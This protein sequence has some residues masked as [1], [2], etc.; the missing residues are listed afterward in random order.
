[1]SVRSHARCP[2][3]VAIG[4]C[5][6]FVQT[7]SAQDNKKEIIEP[8]YRL[9]RKIDVSSG[10]ATTADSAANEA[11]HANEHATTIPA[12]LSTASANNPHPLDRALEMAE[13]GLT[14]IRENIR[15][16]KAIMVKRERVNGE[17]LEP[18]FMEVKIRNA[19]QVGSSQVPF[20]IYMNF[21]KPQS[22][23]GRE[24]IWVQGKN[25]NKI[26]AHETGIK[27]LVGTVR[28]DPNGSLAMT[29]N[30]Y[31]IYEAGIE[32]LVSKL[33]E[34]GTRDRAAGPCEVKYVEDVKLNKRSCTMIEVIH[35]EKKAPYEFHKA[36]IFI[37]DELQVPV[38]Y[39]SYLWPTTPGEK[40]PLLE[41]YTYVNMELNIGLTDR[42]FDHTNP[43]Y[44][45]K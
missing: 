38:R 44:N 7:G 9:S 11:G 3:A 29:G 4:C 39:A 37:D 10:G 16:Y 33:L 20:S 22:V 32:N 5:L 21:L 30:R 43:A 41:E 23:K 27:S 35:H 8:I 6:A 17:L 25:D 28:L 19:R 34:K 42:D 26:L 15:D 31:P 18:E 45:Y 36:Q 2:I 14:N 12:T 40:P 24:V 1:M 13:S